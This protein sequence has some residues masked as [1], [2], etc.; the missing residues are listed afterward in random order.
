MR[1]VR[2]LGKVLELVAFGAGHARRGAL[3]SLNDV[4]TGCLD[5]RIWLW[6]GTEVCAKPATAARTHPSDP[7][8][9]SSGSHT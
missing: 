8:V 4:G 1:V 9:E 6:I 5:R 2:Q 7:I 3:Q